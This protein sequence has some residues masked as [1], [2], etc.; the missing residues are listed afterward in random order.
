MEELHSAGGSSREQNGSVTVVLQPHRYVHFKIRAQKYVKSV[1]P[2]HL[3]PVQIDHRLF[4]KHELKRA[5]T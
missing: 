3:Q 4:A 5:Q 2:E 1:F